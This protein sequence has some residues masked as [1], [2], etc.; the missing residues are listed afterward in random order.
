MP[1]LSQLTTVLVATMIVLSVVGTATPAGTGEHGEPSP[2]DGAVQTLENGEDLYFVFGAEDDN[3]SLDAFLDDHVM[4]ASGPIADQEAVSDVLE[5]QDIDEVQLD[6]QGNA[7]SIAIDGGEATAVQEANQQ[8][9]N[10]RV[11]EVTTENTVAESERT[12]FENVG[13]VHIIFGAGD[14]R[15]FDGWAIADDAGDGDDRHT[16]SART[17][18]TQDQ[19]TN[20][21]NYN[22]Q[23]IAFAI[24]EDNS[25]AVA[26]QQSKQ[27]NHNVQEG[28]ANATTVLESDGGRAGSGSTDQSAETAVDQSQSVAQENTNQQGMAV[29]IAVGSD[30]VA[31]AIQITEQSNLNEQIAAVETVTD[32]QRMGMNVATADAGD[33]SVLSTND[34]RETGQRD[35]EPSVTQYQ[36]AEQVNINLQSAAVAIATNESEATA[37]QFA[38]QRNYNEQAAFASATSVHNGLGAQINADAGVVTTNET[39]LTI[40]GNDVEGDAQIAFD[41]DNG[42]EQ[43]TDIE[44]YSTAEI[45]QLQLVDQEN[46]NQQQTAI[47]VAR[48]GGSADASQITIQEN[49]NVQ[50]ATAESLHFGAAGSGEGDDDGDGSEGP[51]ADEQAVE[52]ELERP[53]ETSERTDGVE[54]TVVESADY[55]ADEDESIESSPGLGVATALVALLA[56]AMLAARTQD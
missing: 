10:S 40:G 15:Q 35:A 9:V 31:T 5:Y 18:V 25:E 20:Q 6:Q 55:E 33:S 50:F 24:A 13:D 26:F 8:N 38:E 11:C 34:G 4:N 43:A 32:L 7:I 3:K 56:A 1:K 48:D 45:E 36:S 2:A 28:S 54:E 46:I 51:A 27:S 52:S 37:I 29:A 30:S 47:A 12:T 53:A 21:V 42:S 44:Q 49:R 22:D 16:Q 14:D 41:Y 19:E 39:A 17:S 23:S